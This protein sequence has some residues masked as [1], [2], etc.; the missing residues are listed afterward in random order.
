MNAHIDYVLYNNRF[1]VCRVEVME[2]LRLIA[3]QLSNPA[4]LVHV[5]SRH[6][7]LPAGA[8]AML[9]PYQT[10]RTRLYECACHSPPPQTDSHRHADMQA[11][12]DFPFCTLSL[13]DA[14]DA[15]FEL[16][17]FSAAHY[18]QLQQPDSSGLVRV[19]IVRTRNYSSR[20]CSAR[21]AAPVQPPCHRGPYRKR[22]RRERIWQQLRC[23]PRGASSISVC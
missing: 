15:I 13:P 14:M 4:T 1:T 18:I 6:A 9:R 19:R 20:Q 22:A 8:S 17:A 23:L 2:L 3:A 21:I 10:S 16:Y 11:P 5:S 7:I 12:V